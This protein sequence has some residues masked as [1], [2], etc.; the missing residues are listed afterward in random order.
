MLKKIKISNLQIGKINFCV[1]VFATF[2]VVACGG[3]GGSASASGSNS[4]GGSGSTTVATS[5]E[6]INGIHVPPEPDATINNSTISGVDSN[7]NGI[8]DDVDRV[9]ASTFGVDEKKYLEAIKFATAEQLLI[10]VK[11]NESV[12][13]YNKTVDCTSLTADESNVLT[14]Q[15]L[16]NPARRAIYGE[17]LAGSLIKK[18]SEY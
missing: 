16:N 15:L 3:G 1:L 11:N 13:S 8:R 5:S 14:Y 6:V 2:L 7:N 17:A 9:L 12:A 4:S 18:C 10:T